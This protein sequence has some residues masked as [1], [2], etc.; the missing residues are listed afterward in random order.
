MSTP[1]DILSLPS[2]A[3]WLKADLHVH[4]PASA[5]IAEA[6]KTATPADVVR[7]AIEKSLDII[8]ITDHNTAAW[9]DDVRQAAEGTSL[10]VFPGV[11]ISTPQG[12]LLAIFDNTVSS[13]HI[14]DLL[15]GLEISRDQF[16]SLHVATEKGIVGASESIEKAGGV[17]IAAHAD[18]ERGFLKMISVG[19]ERER[20]YMAQDLRAIEILDAPSREEYQSGG[21]YPRR[22][23]CVQS[24]DCWPKGADHHQL[25][26]M[27]YRYSLL[28]MGE[29]SISG[30]K[31][32][33]LD[34]EIRVRL[35]Q[36]ESPSPSVAILGMWV[37]GG[38]LDGQKIRFNENVSCFIGD[39]GSGKSVAI[40][41]LRFG[42]DQQPGV[43]KILQEVE[44][45]LEQQLGKLGTVHILLAKGDTHYLVER[46]WGSPPAKPLV[47]RVTVT[48][49]QPVEELDMRLFFPI[50]C[51]SQ[52][53]IIEFARE[54]EVR[55]TL[56]D[57]LIDCSAEFSSIGDVKTALR[58]NAAEITAEIATERSIRSQLSERAGLIEA[59]KD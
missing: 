24:S 14:E 37:T 4:T 2:G 35:P 56:T 16:G 3:Q 19:A 1:N 6:W 5:D 29:R 33:L 42:L 9:C 46:A 10:T 34:P 17:A 43:T 41:L 49:S 27:A 48:G 31:L 13:S 20:A 51:F 44:G 18:G 11:E 57:D 8:A 28:K 7:I 30:L 58:K 38:F 52:S 32:A 23:T 55:L 26:G 15:I 21:R 12:H 25:D 36:D 50:K 54:P 40:E 22:M 47:Q 39:T 53:E 59:T 45:L